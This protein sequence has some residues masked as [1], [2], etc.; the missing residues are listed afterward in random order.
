ML[1]REDLELLE[2]SFLP[3]LERHHLRLLAH[4]LRTFQTIAAAS[5]DPLTL[6][7]RKQIEVWVATQPTIADD[8]AFLEAFLEQLARLLDPLQ[9][10]ASRHQQ[11]LLT[12]QMPQLVAW[13]KEQADG[14]LSRPDQP[15]G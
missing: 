15:R 14:R 7:D 2:A 8:P 3:A 1:T 13:A 11:P 10:I 6:P 5:G 4:G 12:L 9:D